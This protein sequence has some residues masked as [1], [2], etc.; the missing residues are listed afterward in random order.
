MLKFFK[1][2]SSVIH[3]KNA[4]WFGILLLTSGWMFVLGIFVGRGTAPV[5][6]DIEKLQ[7]ELIALKE[8]KSQED[9]DKF[10]QYMEEAQTKT[11]LGFY[12]TLKTDEPKNGKSLSS[13]KT[14]PVREDKN[15]QSTDILSLDEENKD[16]TSQNMSSELL[17]KDGKKN[18]TIQIASLR[19]MNNADNMVKR[20]KEQGYQ[21]AYRS[22]A[23]IPDKGIWYR[24]RVGFYIDKT[25]AQEILNHLKQAK[26]TPMLISA[27]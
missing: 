14:G 18:L 9:K 21:D 19:D 15:S 13:F 23:H 25:E 16:I 3:F 2:I 4:K 1:S 20:L 6:F 8:A 27:Q 22:I 17:S 24:V 11:D 10:K 7:K 26:Y 5:T 12:E